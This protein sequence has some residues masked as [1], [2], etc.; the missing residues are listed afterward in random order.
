MEPRSHEPHREMHEPAAPGGD[1]RLGAEEAR[2]LSLETEN[3]P[4]A[5]Q[6]RQNAGRRPPSAVRED[7]AEGEA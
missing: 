7:E 5:V 4:G 1:R 2:E 6:Y 3:S